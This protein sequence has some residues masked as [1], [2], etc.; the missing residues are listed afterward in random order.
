MSDD[1]LAVIQRL[2]TQV[3]ELGVRV[4]SVPLWATVTNIRP[5]RIRFDR[6]GEELEATPHNAAGTVRA[7]DRVL[8]QRYGNQVYVWGPHVELDPPIGSRSYDGSGVSIASGA[9]AT[10][11]GYN[12]A[13]LHRGITYGSGGFTILT[14]GIYT[15][16][17][18]A[19]FSG[20]SSGRR[21]L[22]FMLNGNNTFPQ[23]IETFAHPTARPMLAPTHDLHLDVGN[24]VHMRAFQDS[25]S[26][27]T[28][29]DIYFTCK[30]YSE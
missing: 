16:S 2:Q 4:P 25:G 23:N 5:L 28:M 19:T 3:N 22:R 20:N 30:L 29:T 27:L 12:S 18:A 24:V 6:E 1:L 15:L 21:G 17:G 8:V 14:P 10:V 7:G 9:W 11:Y 13:P 26:T